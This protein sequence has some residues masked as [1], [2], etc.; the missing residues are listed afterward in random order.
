MSIKTYLVTVSKTWEV[1]AHNADS[2]LLQARQG[3]QELVDEAYHVRPK[4]PKPP[5]ERL[6]NDPQS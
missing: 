1:T 3:S 4:P 2:A 6:P 5:P